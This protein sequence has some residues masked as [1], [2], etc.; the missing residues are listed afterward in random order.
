MPGTTPGSAGVLINLPAVRRL[1]SYGTQR[2]GQGI[3]DVT[4]LVIYA[5][6]VYLVLRGSLLSW[7]RGDNC[8]SIRRS[9]S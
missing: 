6:V 2:H 1:S 5:S 8:K 3:V 4:G 7:S 9:T